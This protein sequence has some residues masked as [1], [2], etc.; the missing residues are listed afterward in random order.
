LVGAHPTVQQP[1]HCPWL[2]VVVAD[3][4]DEHFERPPLVAAHRFHVA[5]VDGE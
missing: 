3:L 2:A 4:R 5:A 1:L